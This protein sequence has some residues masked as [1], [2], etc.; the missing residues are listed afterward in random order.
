MYKNFTLLLLL[1]HYPVSQ[2][3]HVISH[4][5][6]TV[7]ADVAGFLQTAEQRVNQYVLDDV[8]TFASSAVR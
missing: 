8:Y 4:E 2:Q 3:F 6:I 5:D 7:D 1:Q